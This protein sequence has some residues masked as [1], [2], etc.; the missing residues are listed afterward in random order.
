MFAA[1]GEARGAPEAAIRGNSGLNRQGM[2]IL[3]SACFENEKGTRSALLPGSFL[4]TEKE[5]A[6]GLPP[7]LEF[8]LRWIVSLSSF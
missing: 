6:E 2:S 8:L 1:G 4:M 7:L 3:F 5:T